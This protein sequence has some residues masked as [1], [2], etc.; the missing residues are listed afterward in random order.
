MPAAAPPGGL[1]SAAGS[2]P[3]CGARVLGRGRDTEHRGVLR[4]TLPRAKSKRPEGRLLL[5][6]GTSIY[7]S[8]Y[9]VR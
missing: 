2:R 4:A 9:Y 5:H 1:G 8:I 3:P 6:V 7:L